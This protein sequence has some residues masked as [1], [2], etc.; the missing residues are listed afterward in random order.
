MDS[1][2]AQGFYWFLSIVYRNY[3]QYTKQLIAVLPE[4]PK[5]TLQ[6]DRNCCG[7][8]E[9]LVLGYVLGIQETFFL[10]DLSWFVWMQSPCSAPSGSDLGISCFLSQPVVTK[11]GGKLHKNRARKVTRHRKFK[12]SLGFGQG[13]VYEGIWQSDYKRHLAWAKRASL[14]REKW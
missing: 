14:Y 9:H 8:I 6:G 10:Q 11:Q 7:E 12:L 4:T 2:H 3:G 1:V 5:H 13:Y